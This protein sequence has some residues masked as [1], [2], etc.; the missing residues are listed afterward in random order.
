LLTEKEEEIL[1]ELV[2]QFG[3]S[4]GDDEAPYRRQR[5]STFEETHYSMTTEGYLKLKYEALFNK[6]IMSYYFYLNKVGDMDSE[7]IYELLVQFHL[8]NFATKI[9]DVGITGEQL[10]NFEEIV[11]QW[12]NP[13]EEDSEKRQIAE[14]FARTKDKHIDL[15]KDFRSKMVRLSDALYDENI[16]PKNRQELTALTVNNIPP[17][18]Q[19]LANAKHSQH[20]QHYLLKLWR[21]ITHQ[22]RLN[23]KGSGHGDM[24]ALKQEFLLDYIAYC[25]SAGNTIEL[26][27][28][29]LIS[30]SGT[31]N[32]LQRESSNFSGKYELH[33]L[34]SGFIR[35]ST[36]PISAAIQVAQFLEQNR[37]KFA[38]IEQ[39]LLAIISEMQQI[40]VGHLEDIHSNRLAIIALE[41]N[42]TL[43]IAIESRL[44]E[45]VSSDRVQYLKQLMWTR[46][47]SEL[48]TQS[49]SE[50]FRNRSSE[51]GTWYRTLFDDYI[52]VITSFFSSRLFHHSGWTLMWEFFFTTK[53]QMSWFFSPIGKIQI[54][55]MMYAIYLILLI[56]VASNHLNV[57][58]EWTIA[59]LVFWSCN[60]SFLWAEIRQIYTDKKAY[61]ED[62]TNFFD[63]WVNV[64]YLLLGAVRFAGI[65]D[66]EYDILNYVGCDNDDIELCLEN[67]LNLLYVTF[68]FLLIMGVCMRIAWMLVVFYN[69][70]LMLRAMYTFLGDFT[71]FMVL[72]LLFLFGFSLSLHMA[73]N[74]ETKTNS[75]ESVW[76]SARAL[77]YGILGEIDYTQVINDR[78]C[79]EAAH[80]AGLTWIEADCE[81]NIEGHQRSFINTVLLILWVVLAA[82]LFINF[83]IAVFNNS[84]AAV[85]NEVDVWVKF[86]RMK[87]CR[88]NDRKLPTIPAPFQAIIW[89][90]KQGWYIFVEPVVF[91]VTGKLINEERLIC[92]F[93]HFKHFY[94]EDFYKEKKYADRL[95]LP[96]FVEFNDHI[97]GT[98]DKPPRSCCERL[99]FLRKATKEA[100]S[101]LL[102]VDSD[103]TAEKMDPSI[104]ICGYCRC[105]NYEFER[106]KRRAESYSD[107]I[108]YYKYNDLLPP[109]FGF[110]DADIQFLE[111]ITPS[112]CDNCFRLRF[113]V[114]RHYVIESM[115]A[116]YF[117]SFLSFVV[118]KLPLLCVLTAILITG[119]VLFMITAMVSILV[120]KVWRCLRRCQR[121]CCQCCRFGEDD[122]QRFHE[123]I[124]MHQPLLAQRLIH[125]SG[126]ISRM[127]KELYEGDAG[128]SS[129]AKELLP[130]EDAEDQYNQKQEELKKE[131]ANP[132]IGDLSDSDSDDDTNSYKTLK[133]T[134]GDANK[135]DLV[136]VMTDTDMNDEQRTNFS[137]LLKA[138]DGQ[139]KDEEEQT[140]IR[141]RYHHRVKSIFYPK[142]VGDIMEEIVSEGNQRIV[143][144][145]DAYRKCMKFKKNVSRIVEEERNS[146]SAQHS[147]KYLLP[148]F[149]IKVMPLRH[150]L[151]YN[152]GQKQKNK[153]SYQVRQSVLATQQTRSKYQ[154]QYTPVLKRI[155]ESNDHL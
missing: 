154:F 1:Q 43:D 10:I 72:I 116:F 20:A 143:L 142:K 54:E 132:F 100:K 122:E 120:F 146:R 2:A 18:I 147:A 86:S 141:T 57:Y 105:T 8:L 91:V 55:F 113:W 41:A 136:L 87:V 115:I 4:E 70:G 73:S 112:L 78:E 84:F 101:G 126:V 31:N 81:N 37:R 145:H 29:L 125:N 124:T 99:F 65:F 35:G 6:V 45:F 94:K 59:E 9:V 33:I 153:A 67:E 110:S 134:R 38:E 51:S 151:K 27:T 128:M 19:E 48:L 34:L 49:S 76:T 44:M 114:K 7:E 26:I 103:K 152:F 92:S 85:N 77:T 107:I 16:V 123:S 93:D 149:E 129:S 95:R 89:L 88:A 119:S 79:V 118:F 3:G 137:E 58:S 121:C 5:G 106:D 139:I 68:W 133:N 21:L 135:Y 36:N 148:E 150:S 138:A 66:T 24:S 60:V 109:E 25:L 75:F 117:Y 46:S 17:A 39:D 83:I 61:F 62:Q 108:R 15:L 56:S 140:L 82:I 12:L 155:V 111:H 63:V 23:T 13:G 104:W 40:A 130:T 22:R 14:L 69:L 96:F 32:Q 50:N 80:A 74:G 53:Y 144:A 131:N 52:L 64:M 28:Q 102:Y 127:D 98:P 42:S 30:W 97:H 11:A 71:N 47:G 90:M